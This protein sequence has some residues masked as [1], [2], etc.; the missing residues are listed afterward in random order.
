[1][2]MSPTCFCQETGHLKTW[3]AGDIEDGLFQ[4][5]GCLLGTVSWEV[6]QLIASVWASPRSLA[7]L[8]ARP[9]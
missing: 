9:R 4:G 3:R 8:V 5:K 2:I 1:M 6:A 7:G